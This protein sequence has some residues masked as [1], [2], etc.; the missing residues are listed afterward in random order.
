[1]SHH[2]SPFTPLNIAVLTVSDTR[3]FDTDTSGRHLKESAES[4]GHKIGD[5]KIVKDDIY[6]LR[7]II[8]NW[9][10]SDDIQ[11]ILVTGGTGFT[12]RDSTPEA[13]IPLFDKTIGGFGELF[14]SLSYDE[15]DCSTIQSRAIAGLA[16]GT[17]IFCLPGSTNACRLGWSKIIEKQLDSSFRPCNFVPH[18]KKAKVENCPTRE[19]SDAI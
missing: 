12:A 15:I 4:S 11:A 13:L 19:H 18:L 3:N 16:N 2:A 9:V 5:Y 6:A 1:M 14:R 7:A 10:A 17:V 8:S